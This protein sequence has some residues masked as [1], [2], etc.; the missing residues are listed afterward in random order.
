M[1]ARREPWAPGATPTPCGP[2]HPLPRVGGDQRRPHHPPAPAW[3]PLPRAR[4]GHV[5]GRRRAGRRPDAGSR[6]GTG[7]CPTRSSADGRRLLVHGVDAA[8]EG[9]RSIELVVGPRHVRRARPGLALRQDVL[10]EHEVECVDGV[11]VTSPIRTAVDLASRAGHVEGVIAVDALAHAFGFHPDELLDHPVLRDNPR[12]RRRLVAVVADADARAES[13]PE[14][15]HASDPARRTHPTAGPA[16]RRPRRRRVFRRARRLRVARSCRTALEYQ[17]DHH[18]TEKKQWRRDAVRTTELAG[19]GWLVLPVTA[20][21]LFVDPRGFVHRVRVA[22]AQRRSRAR[23]PLPVITRAKGT[24]ASASGGHF[25]SADHRQA[26]PQT[27]RDR[28]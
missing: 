1:G 19:C 9:A 15:R 21:D 2:R 27:A 13:P 4:A 11:A 18:R 26:A 10:G 20:Y 24:R 6:R 3:P 17:G 25:R 12:G 14:T 8:P 22:L 28:P 7:A 16:A 5:R 23:R